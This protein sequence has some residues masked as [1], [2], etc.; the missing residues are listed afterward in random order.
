[1][2]IRKLLLDP[3]P[4]LKKLKE[5]FGDGTSQKLPRV[6]TE[7]RRIVCKTVIRLNDSFIIGLRMNVVNE[8]I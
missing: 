7:A 5:Q 8:L 3:P 2:A 1:M 6:S 4:S